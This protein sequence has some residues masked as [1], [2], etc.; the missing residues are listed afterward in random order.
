MSAYTLGYDKNYKCFHCEQ[1]YEDVEELNKN[2]WKCPKCGNHI[3]IAAP[4]LGSGHTMIRKK[5][6]E[7]KELDLVHIVGCSD[8]YSVIKLEKKRN[9]KVAVALK[10][11][12]KPEFS[13]NDFVS[14]I[15]GGYYEDAWK[16]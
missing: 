10:N 4:E 3:R 15:D 11:Y 7:L 9:Q 12:G 5:V 1:F 13:A 16:I 8:S 6:K 2:S 14:V